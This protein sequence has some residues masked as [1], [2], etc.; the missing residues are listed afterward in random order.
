MKLFLWLNNGSESDFT[1]RYNCI[2]P[3]SSNAHDG[4]IVVLAKSEE[5]AIKLINDYT[6]NVD[7][8][9]DKEECDGGTIDTKPVIIPIDKKGVVLYCDG[10][11]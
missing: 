1:D 9:E 7:I 2:M 5:E 4:G 3:N 11:C 8:R 10:D 6:R